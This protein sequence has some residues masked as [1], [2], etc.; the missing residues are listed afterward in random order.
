MSRSGSVCRTHLPP[1]YDDRGWGG[2][3]GSNRMPTPEQKRSRELL[4][5]PN[6]IAR[7]LHDPRRFRRWRCGT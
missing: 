1:R 6:L 2:P 5:P 7:H 4:P 3:A